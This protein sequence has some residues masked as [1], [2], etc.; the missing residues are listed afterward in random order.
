[1]TDHA[2]E[3][4]FLAVVV[5]AFGAEPTLSRSPC[6]L[7]LLVTRFLLALICPLLCSKK[8]YSPKKKREK[9]K[10]IQKKK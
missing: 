4:V 5:S 3:T 2:Y 6:E 1:M 9:E 7:P 8:G 10:K